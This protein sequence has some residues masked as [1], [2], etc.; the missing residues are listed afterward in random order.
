MGDT[1]SITTSLSTPGTLNRSEISSTSSICHSG[2][3]CSVAKEV[4]SFNIPKH[5]SFNSNMVYV[6]C[7][8]LTIHGVILSVFLRVYSSNVS[9]SIVLFLTW[10]LDENFGNDSISLQ[11]RLFWLLW[12][13]LLVENYSPATAPKTLMCGNSVIN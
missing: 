10:N 5:F 8:G 3:S 2:S 12:F 9:F 11:I 6:W 1:H 7:I 4:F 13:F